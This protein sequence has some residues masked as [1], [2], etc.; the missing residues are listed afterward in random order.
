NP[1]P[2]V[3]RIRLSHPCWP[4]YP[5]SIL[6]QTSDSLGIPFDS[7]F[8]LDALGGYLIGRRGPRGAALHFNRDNRAADLLRSKEAWHLVVVALPRDRLPALH[9]GLHTLTRQFGHMSHG[10]LSVSP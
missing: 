9:S 7:Y 5:A 4:P 3:N 10:I 8:T 2:K 1:L 6:N